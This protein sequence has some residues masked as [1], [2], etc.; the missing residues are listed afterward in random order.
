MKLVEIYKALLKEE[1]QEV[2]EFVVS[3]SFTNE[4]GQ[5][6]TQYRVTG[7]HGGY[8]R[9]TH[10]KDGFEMTNVIIEEEIRGKGI[11]TKFYIKTNEESVRET[12]KT[13]QSTKPDK[14]GLI[15]LSPDGKSLWDSLVKKGLAKRIASNRYRFK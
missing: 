11:A 6:V 14:T 10:S 15:E 7:G 13:L 2:P 12:G 8:A 1:T 9:V 5:K 3:H 4:K